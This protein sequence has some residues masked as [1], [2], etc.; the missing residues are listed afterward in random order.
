[1]D[2]DSPPPPVLLS[3]RLRWLIRERTVVM[4]ALLV[5]AALV[6]LGLRTTLIFDRLIPEHREQ[7]WLDLACVALAIVLFSAS[8]LF[9]RWGMSR[10]PQH[11]RLWGMLLAGT[12][13][14]VTT[15][16]VFMMGGIESHA[17]LLYVFPV[18]HAAL[19]LS[20]L[21]TY[22]LA[23]LAANGYG[24]LLY[25]QYLGIL[26]HP[27]SYGLNLYRA[28]PFLLSAYASLWGVLTLVAIVGN[29]IV[30]QLRRREREV[31]RLN[32]ELARSNEILEA[33]LAENARLLQET[34]RRRDEIAALLH[35]IADGVLVTDGRGTLLM[36]NP[37]AEAWLGIT[38]ALAAGSTVTSAL[39]RHP[40]LINLLAGPESHLVSRELTLGSRVCQVQVHPIF[41]QGHDAALA[42]TQPLAQ[43]VILLDVTGERE[44]EQAKADFFNMIAHDLRTPLTS[45]SAILRTLLMGRM[46]GLN[47]EQCD[48]L[49]T[50]LEQADLLQKLI[51]QIL[52]LARLDAREFRIEQAPVALGALIES[53]VDRL[54]LLA[55]EK[56]LALTAE[57]PPDL[58]AVRGDAERLEQ[59]LTNLVHNA[60]KFTATGGVQIRVDTPADDL[61]QIRVCDSGPGI[62]AA[63]LPYVFERF[64]QGRGQQKGG[65][66]LGLA[67]CKGIVEAHG[68]RIWAEGQLGRGSTFHVVLPLEPG[69]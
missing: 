44:L 19:L 24:L 39:G 3:Q 26:P 58:P 51:D 14:L 45:N 12:D 62:P 5:T 32:S 57:T 23:I 55:E 63:D 22:L 27:A 60:I 13:V 65:A 11:A 43:V 15:V 38:E 25:L 33:R 21:E 61:L 37:V 9:T 59:V 69:R 6:A 56:G 52:D 41:S 54:H 35:G 17:E 1:M 66:G 28:R 16:V 49:Q 46:G 36:V 68:G 64:Y 48:F 4:V 67:I 29:Y 53:V 31:V 50:A 2:Q 7:A 34:A 20:P 42:D 8:W 47:E 30:A 10:A 18:L 40:D